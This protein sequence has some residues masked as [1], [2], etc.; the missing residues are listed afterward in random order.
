MD[1]NK[2]KKILKTLEDAE[3]ALRYYQLCSQ[4]EFSDGN[5]WLLALNTID[6]ICN[7]RKELKDGHSRK[8]SD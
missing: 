3:K 7:L 8:H 1:E 2:Y 5:S 4:E 6:K